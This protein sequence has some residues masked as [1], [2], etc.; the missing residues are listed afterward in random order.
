[1]L[2]ST[3][4]SSFNFL[5]ADHQPHAQFVTYQFL[6]ITHC[7]YFHPLAAYPGPLLARSTRLWYVYYLATGKLPFA[8]K[9]AHDTYGPTVRVAPDELSFVG[10]DAFKAIYGYKH[11]TGGEMPKDPNM[12]GNLSAGTLSIIGA[13]S[14]RHGPLRRLLSHGFSEKALRFQEP[15]IQGYL[16]LF[17]RRLRDLGAKG[18]DIDIVTWYN[19][20]DLPSIRLHCDTT[21]D[22]AVL[23]LRCDR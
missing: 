12:Y 4:P 2:S 18:V 10:E 16:D 7:L 15:I 20:S 21:A 11:G 13:P 9:A 17:I 8:V 22:C 6:T 3:D 5:I 1:V 19:V 23:H 14:H